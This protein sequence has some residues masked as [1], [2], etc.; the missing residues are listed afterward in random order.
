MSYHFGK[1]G[2]HVDS[3]TNRGCAFGGSCGGNKKAGIFGGSISWPQGNMGRRVFKRAPQRIPS[4]WFII[5]HTTK[6]PVQQRRATFGVIRGL[7]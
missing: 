2:R 3:L 1:Q 4:K 7:M 5:T 6:H